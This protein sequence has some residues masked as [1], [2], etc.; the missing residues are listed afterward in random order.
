MGSKITSI[1]I[2]SGIKHFL[3]NKNMFDLK[4]K[5][6]CLPQSKLIKLLKFIKNCSVR[7]TE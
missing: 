4:G 5:D 7:I 2:L 3:A 1:F 6:I